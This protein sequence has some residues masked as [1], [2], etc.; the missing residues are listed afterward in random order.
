MLELNFDKKTREILQIG[1]IWKEL[2]KEIK[3]FYAFKQ[4]KLDFDQN[5][6][7]VSLWYSKLN[8]CFYSSVSQVVSTLFIGGLKLL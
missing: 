7:I 1:I 8:L 4:L 5:L 6:Y 3:R 2:N